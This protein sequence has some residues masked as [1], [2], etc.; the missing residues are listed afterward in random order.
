LKISQISANNHQLKQ[1]SG[2]YPAHLV[3]KAQ[4]NSNYDLTLPQEIRILPT[5][6]EQG[7]GACQIA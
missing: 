5:R 7:G 6:A 1:L 3:E 2:H 4:D